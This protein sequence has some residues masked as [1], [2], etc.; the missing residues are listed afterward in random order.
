MKGIVVHHNGK[1]WRTLEG[2]VSN[3]RLAIRAITPISVKQEAVNQG[4]AVRRPVYFVFSFRGQTIAA[5]KNVTLK[6]GRRYP[7]V[8]HWF[9]PSEL[10]QHL[11]LTQL[12]QVS[13]APALA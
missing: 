1:L 9:I 3:G 4:C 2:R 5:A 8:E 12:Q 6:K 7:D 11:E 13:A 10:K